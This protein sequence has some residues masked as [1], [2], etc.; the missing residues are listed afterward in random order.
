MK[1]A[2]ISNLFPPYVLGGAELMASSLAHELAKQNHQVYVITTCA[3][4]S[5]KTK[6]NLSQNLEKISFFPENRYWIYDKKRQY[7]FDK[8][9]WHI[10]D[11]WNSSVAKELHPILSEIKPDI[12]HTHN[13]D[14]FSPAIWKT[15]KDMNVPL[16][17]TAHDGHLICPK[18]NF[19]HKNQN[20]DCSS[21]LCKFYRKWYFSTTKYIDHFVTP[22]QFLLNLHLEKGLIS[23]QSSVIANG[24]NCQALVKIP[25]TDTPI[26]FLFIGGL[27]QEK[28]LD[29]VL[30]VFQKLPADKIHLDIAGKGPLLNQVLNTSK[31][32]PNINY[33]GF[34]EENDKKQA[35]ENADAMIFASRC[36]E[37][38]SLSTL[39]GLQNGLFVLAS[40]IGAVP[41]LIQNNFNGML[42]Q[43]NSQVDM[44]LKIIELLKMDPIERQKI[45]QNALTSGA[46][47]TLKNM[48]K[49]YIQLYQSLV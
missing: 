1:I 39:E 15:I 17:H 41:E 25:L 36:Y 44:R 18:A 30:E 22:S 4:N 19:V 11:A 9:L 21:F 32:Y 29:L 31:Q 27:N 28:G 37:S 43:K 33:L 6:E 10:N 35:F 12:V 45:R 2:I 40:N 38:F 16:V 13:I 5:P 26:K 23:P 7:F 49:N 14:S 48:I 8:Y 20:I 34:I 46:K 47:F 3:A 42:F 24:L